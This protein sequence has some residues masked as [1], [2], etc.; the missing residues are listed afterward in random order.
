MQL[1]VPPSAADAVLDV[2][3]NLHY[4]VNEPTEAEQAT[5]AAATGAAVQ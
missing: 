1:K 5:A 4:K 2:R 3:F